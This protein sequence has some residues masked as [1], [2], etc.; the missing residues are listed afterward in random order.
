M[1]SDIA[2]T[3]RF[4]LTGASNPF[5]LDQHFV[6]HR[7]GRY[8]PTIGRPF[9]H[10]VVLTSLLLLS[11]PHFYQYL[12]PETTTMPSLSLNTVLTFLATI[13]PGVAA[14]FFYTRS[15]PY[16]GQNRCQ[17]EDYFH[18]YNCN[19]GTCD[20]SLQ[21]WVFTIIA[22]IVLSFLLSIFCSLLRCICCSNRR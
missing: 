14:D 1:A 6:F 12:Q 3:F 18:Y 17:R 21:P 22:F 7:A 20:F 16:C 19:D 15:T 10:F 2:V 11:F 13:I 9:G 4:A 8:R 5:S